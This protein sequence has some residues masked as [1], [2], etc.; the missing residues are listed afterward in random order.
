MLSKIVLAKVDGS[1]ITSNTAVCWL[2]T[3]AINI[4]GLPVESK[5][6]LT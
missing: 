2:Y 5:F 3:Q 6:L 1:V 4:E